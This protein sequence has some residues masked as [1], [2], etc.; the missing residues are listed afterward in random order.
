MNTHP[1]ALAYLN[2]LTTLQLPRRASD[3]DHIWF[4]DALIPCYY[5][6]DIPLSCVA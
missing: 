6:P 2:S 3:N 5:N 1:V 4:F